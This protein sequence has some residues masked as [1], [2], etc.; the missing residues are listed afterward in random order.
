MGIAISYAPF[1]LEQTRMPKLSRQ[2]STVFSRIRV[3]LRQNSDPLRH[4]LNNRAA[5]RRSRCRHVPAPA[6]PA[7][8]AQRQPPPP[9]PP[10]PQG[11]TFATVA[12][13]R[14]HPSG[15]MD[16]RHDQ[17]GRQGHQEGAAAVA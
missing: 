8:R 5:P 17:T 2:L 16:G 12:A 13:A 10:G 7:A 1:F 11:R 6:P 4:P 14:P 3:L 15:R 9:P